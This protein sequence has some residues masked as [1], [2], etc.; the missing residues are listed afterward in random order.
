VPF[1]TGSTPSLLLLAGIF[2][3]NFFARIFFA[4]LLPEL[5]LSLGLSHGQAGLFF[6]FISC[7]YFVSMLG[8][9]LVSARI[10][11]KNTI[12]LSITGITLALALIQATPASP[13]FR[14]SF[15][16]LGLSA[17][18]YLPSAV[19]TIAG[20][21]PPARMGRAFGIHELAPNLAFVS[22]PLYVA[23][24]LPHMGWQ[25]IIRLLL[26]PLVA[27]T[28]CYA[29][30]GKNPD[31]KHVPPS[32]A[33]YSAVF[34]NRSF[35]LMVLL[36]SVGIASTLGIYSI[37]PTYLV[38]IHG[39]GEQESNLLIAA[40]RVPTVLAALA[41]G[42]L[43]DRFGKR[44]AMGLVLAGSGLATILLSQGIFLVKIGIWLQPI[45]AVCFFP[46][47]FAM[48]SSIGPIQ[49]RSIVVSVTIPLAFVIGGGVVPAIIARLADH[50]LFAG[51][52]SGTGIIML[53]TSILV[54]GLQEEPPRGTTKNSVCKELR[55]SV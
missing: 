29:M 1:P 34:A 8:S 31:K 19:A 4:P 48:L 44:R 16:F 3:F 42:F 5:E 33:L 47:G 9:N 26:P 14:P 36:F 25:Q 50:G 38:S 52:I 17:G 39:F 27:M 43:A 41:G 2:F 30:L 6:L 32:L 13:L 22:A 54:I 11:H 18:L 51:A 35:W 46:A 55:R 12:L 10:G 49:A 23:L 20:L 24:L 53:L 37:L 28:V 40:T 21:F 45:I 7:G 15:V